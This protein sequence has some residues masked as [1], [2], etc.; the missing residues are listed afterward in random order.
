MY[1]HKIHPS[2]WWYGLAAALAIAVFASFWIFFFALF[3]GLRSGI[4]RV[5]VPGTHRVKITA[6]GTY[7][8][9]SEYEDVGNRKAYSTRED[10]ARNLKC[11]LEAAEGMGKIPVM[12]APPYSTY[13]FGRREG[14]SVF[15]FKIGRPGTY[16]L[17][18][19]YPD[20]AKTPE[21][22]L[23]ISRRLSGAPAGSKTRWCACAI[24]GAR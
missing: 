23:A 20:G 18:A 15:R 5:T 8:V 9:F 3:H 21:I 1:N 10:A 2:T 7:T 11:S 6:A 17:T 4:E 24:C 14:V 16:I 13:K 22:V 12:P 19:E